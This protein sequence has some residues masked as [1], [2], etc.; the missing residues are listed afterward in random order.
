MRFEKAIEL[1]W[2]G[3]RILGATIGASDVLHGLGCAT[4]FL[5]K[6]FLKVILTKSLIT[7]GALDKWV[8]KLFYVT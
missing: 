4:L 8:N 6:C 5:F 1:L 2:L 7:A 3:P